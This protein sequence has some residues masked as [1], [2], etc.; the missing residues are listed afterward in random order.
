LFASIFILTVS[1]VLFAYW[2]RYTCLLILSAQNSRSYAR[3][4]AAANKLSFLDVRTQLLQDEAT[5]ALD[6]LRRALDR[7]YR[8]LAYLLD[9]AATYNLN[10]RSIEERVLI[11]DYYLMKGWYMLTRGVS[12]SLA[13]KALLEMA[14][15]VNHLANTMGERVAVSSRV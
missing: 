8:L 3:Q 1:A 7:D 12:R 11:L 13:R 5:S 4:V 6:G 9:H 2:F 10:G 15:I 14:A